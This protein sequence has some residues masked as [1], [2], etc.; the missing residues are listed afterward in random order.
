M[1]YESAYKDLTSVLKKQSGGSFDVLN[2]LITTLEEKED[3]EDYEEKKKRSD[4]E[5]AELEKQARRKQ[6]FEDEQKTS[7]AFSK[8]FG[9]YFN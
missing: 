1:D 9:K 3:S 7:D 4:K 8:A 5:Q 2:D 6:E